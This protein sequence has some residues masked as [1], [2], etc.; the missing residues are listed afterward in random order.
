MNIS[1]YFA[2]TKGYGVLATANDKGKVNAAIYSKPYFTDEHT[3][4]L[5]FTLRYWRQA[6]YLLRS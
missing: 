3:V 6:C 4:V 2:I 1:E 5:L